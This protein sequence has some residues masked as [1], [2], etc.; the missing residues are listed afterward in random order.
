MVGSEALQK[1]LAKSL[2]SIKW[3][4]V[5][6]KT[7]DNQIIPMPPESRIV[8]VLLQT[9][10]MP[11]IESWAKRHEIAVHDLVEITRG[12]PDVELSGGSLGEKLVAL[13]IKSARYKG[14]DSVSRMTLGTYNGYFLHPN[15]R[16]LVGGKRCYNDYDEHW[17]VAFIYKWNPKKRPLEMVEFVER[18]VAYKWQVASRISGSGDTANIGGMGSLSALRTLKSEF[19]DKD[20]FETYWRDYAIKHPRKRTRAPK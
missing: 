1:D 6:I 19:D 7:T 16:K 11:K 13:D 17:I 12:Y 15:E 8:T 4:I 2:Q 3:N 20:S 5:G 9:L 10:A 18:I 14:G